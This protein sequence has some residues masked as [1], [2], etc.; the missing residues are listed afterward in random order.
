[1]QRKLPYL[2]RE[3][4]RGK[5]FYYVRKGHGK[6]IRI[7]GQFGTQEFYKNYNAALASPN[8]SG[9]ENKNFTHQQTLSYLIKKYR[10]SSEYLNLS[11]STRM[12][13]DRYYRRMEEKLGHFPYAE[14]TRKMILDGREKLRDKPASANDLVKSCRALFKWAVENDFLQN[15]PSI[16]IKKIKYHVNHIAAL[17]EDD[18]CK[19]RGYWPLGT[20]ERLA[21]EF[22]IYTGLRRS[23]IC[24]VGRQ[25]IDGNC[26]R[27]KMQKT[28]E[29]VYI[30]ILQ[31]LRVAM[32][33]VPKDQLVFI[34][35]LDGRP[36]V[37]ESFG[38]WFN[39]SIKKAGINKSMHGVR[40]YRA[41]Q[42]AEYGASEAELNAWFGWKPNSR[43][44]WIY[45]ADAN[46]KKLSENALNRIN[47]IANEDQE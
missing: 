17:T 22:L 9:Q 26:I 42:F 47:Q 30:P 1:M 36:F 37:K 28:R 10:V 39:E 18:V 41:R 11:Q 8:F 16:S 31:Q 43:Q 24:T 7:F 35:T 4:G 15:D 25:H 14:I 19:Y 3:T 34:G 27:L 23:D 13:R 6:R 2:K 38:A 45:T 46:K 44:S 29:E 40:K 32:D 21:L 33:S 20:R 12:C 5:T